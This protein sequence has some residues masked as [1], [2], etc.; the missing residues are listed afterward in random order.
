MSVRLALGVSVLLVSS[1]V[2]DVKTGTVIGPATADQARDLLPEELL[3]RYA[4]GDFANEVAEPKPGSKMMDPDFLAAGDANRGKYTVSDAGTI[5]DP[6]TGK[7]PLYIYGPPFPDVDASDPQAGVK[8]I[9]N[10]FYQSY[11]LGDDH[12][13]VALTWVARHGVDRTSAQDVWQKFFDGQAPDQPRPNNPNNLLFQQLVETTFPADLKG[14]IALTWRYRDTKR[15]NTWAY[16]PALRR[17]RAVSPTNRSDGF[18][19]SDMSQ[20]DG[21]Y[22]DGKPEDFTWKVVG[23]GDMLCLRDRAAVVEGRQDIRKLPEGGWRAVYPPKP[24]FG[25]QAHNDKLVSWAP[26]P[27]RTVLVREHVYRIE[28]VPRD[29]YY[30][31]GKIALRLEKGT[32]RGCYNSKSDWRSTVLNTYTPL[33]GAYFK[34]EDGKGPWRE[35]N[36]AQFTMAQNW[37]LDR[38]T[39]SYARTDDPSNAA[40]SLIT[41]DAKRFDYQSMVEYGR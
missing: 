26:L 5:L 34:M 35:Y 29:T 11:I 39:V 16:V 21:S 19:G 12:N 7:Q 9:W 13:T 10:F 3:E 22:F 40:D 23:E 38:A 1:A 17:V 33:R 8:L 4:K 41:I 28:A 32:F 18:L 25:W 31:Y 6:K 2:A 27:E 30:L 24:R 20:D 37:K 36:E 15:D 14:T